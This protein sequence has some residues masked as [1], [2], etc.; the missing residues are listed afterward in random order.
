MTEQAKGERCAYPNC[1]DMKPW[2]HMYRPEHCKHEPN[3][4]CHPL[5]LTTPPPAP[6]PAKAKDCRCASVMDGRGGM[7]PAHPCEPAPGPAKGVWRW[8]VITHKTSTT[9]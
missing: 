1:A 7:C 8:G 6:E 3:E 4:R 9:H 2:T 5:T